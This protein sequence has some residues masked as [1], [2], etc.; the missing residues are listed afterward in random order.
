MWR[1]SGKTPIANPPAT[2]CRSRDEYKK[3]FLTLRR[4]DR[5]RLGRHLVINKDVEALPP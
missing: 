1:S 2:L 4:S 5:H 3:F